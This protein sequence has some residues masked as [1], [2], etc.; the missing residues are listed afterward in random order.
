MRKHVVRWILRLGLIGA[1]LCV[2]G[3][4]AHAR[5]KNPGILP[6]NAKPHGMSYGEWSA[7]WWQWA[8]SIPADRNPNTDRT[9]KFCAEG[10][11]GSV[12]FLAGTIFLSGDVVRRCTIP[13]GKTLVIP[14][15]SGLFG[16]GVFDCEPT[17]PGV[18]CDVDVLRDS[19]AA[20]ADAAQILEVTIDGEPIADV[21]DYRVVSPEPFAVF[22]PDNNL[23]GVPPGRYYPQVVDGYWLVHT[24]LSRG[25]H[26]IEHHVVA[27]GIV[28]VHLVT[29]VT[30]E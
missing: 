8:L 1:V 30:I 28:D 19:A 16:A 13:T 3:P 24:P 17:A 25:K 12:W 7:A 11:N 22:F 9:G 15:L 20:V 21:K 29:Y 2:Q 14:V 27:P 18:P 4:P 6:V 5:N 26:T 23:V 10:Q